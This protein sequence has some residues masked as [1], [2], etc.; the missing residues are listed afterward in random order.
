MDCAALAGTVSDNEAPQ[1]ATNIQENIPG[2]RIYWLNSMAASIGGVDE[3][4]A[5]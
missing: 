3:A 5:D 4:G 2:P 1:G